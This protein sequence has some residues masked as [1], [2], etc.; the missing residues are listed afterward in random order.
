MTEVTDELKS[1]FLP[2]HELIKKRIKGLIERDYILR[3]PTDRY[4]KTHTISFVPAEYNFFLQTGINIFTSL[5]QRN[6]CLSCNQ[7]SALFKTCRL[8]T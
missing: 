2:S 4:N 6:A 3:A 1:R 5:K 8:L 7:T